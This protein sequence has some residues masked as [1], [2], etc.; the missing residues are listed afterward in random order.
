MPAEEIEKA[1]YDFMRARRTRSVDTD[2]SFEEGAGFVAESWLVKENDPLFADEP[3][4]AWAVGIKVTGE[5]VWERVIKG[6][7][8]G[9]SLAGL[10]RAVEMTRG[11]DE[12]C[13]GINR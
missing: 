6:E 9:L 10:A 5:E 3:A 12:W 13:A 4:G 11:Q 2:H 8:K 1:A 7:L